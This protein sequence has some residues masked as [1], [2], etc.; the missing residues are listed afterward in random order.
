MKQDAWDLLQHVFRNSFE[1]TDF[2]G[3]Y[4]DFSD[5]NQE[6]RVYLYGKWVEGI[7][8][9]F[10]KELELN[11]L[12]FKRDKIA[13]IYLLDRIHKIDEQMEQNS[14]DI[15]LRS[16]QKKST[17]AISNTKNELI[18]RLLSAQNNVLFGFMFSAKANRLYKEVLKSES[19]AF[20]STLEEKIKSG[21]AATT[22]TAFNFSG[23]ASKFKKLYKTLNGNFIS[24]SYESFEDIFKGI[25]ARVI[26]ESIKWIDL[27]PKK[28]ASTNASTLFDFLYL[29][30]SNDLLPK[31]DFNYTGKNTNNLYRKM[32]VCFSDSKGNPIPN[33]RTKTKF[34]YEGKTKRSKELKSIIEQIFQ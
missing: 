2:N 30:K 7:I 20:E 6:N 1:H 27:P 4:I 9:E 22:T 14:Y 8:I 18:I 33:L 25:S 17:N 26:K 5:I 28:N 31:S 11:F 34:K 29:L 32:E 21:K 10:E 13:S 24:G 3:E 15:K 12:E 16:E 19:I 23:D